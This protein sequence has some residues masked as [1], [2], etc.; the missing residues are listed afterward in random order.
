MSWRL[1]PVTTGAA[2]RAVPRFGWMTKKDNKVTIR[3]LISDLVI[4]SVAVTAEVEESFTEK[5]VGTV[6]GKLQE[7]K[8]GKYAYISG[9]KMFALGPDGKVAASDNKAAEAYSWPMAHGVRPAAQSLGAGGCTDCHST[10]AAFFFGKVKGSG[11]LLTDAVAVK[12][13]YELQG[14]DAGFHSMFGLTFVF[15]PIFKT[16]LFTVAILMAAVLAAYAAL[17]IRKTVKCAGGTDDKRRFPTL[18]KLAGLIVCGL[19]AV[20]VVTGFINPVLFSATISGWLLITHVLLGAVFAVALLGLIVFRASECSDAGP[21][22]FNTGQKVGFWLLAVF[23]FAL[24]LTAAL[25][26]L[27]VIGTCWQA[28]MAC[29]HLYMGIGVIAASL[30]YLCGTC[31][32]KKA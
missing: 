5:Q 30:V 2:R 15:R 17:A 23:G 7:A 4:Q 9:G 13:M 26:T 28:T 29:I 27:P 16:V 14:L 12:S 32:K 31:R 1:V 6:L 25:A 24:V 22:R 10:D 18:D 21:G 19:T 3:P 20:L 8:G 11:P